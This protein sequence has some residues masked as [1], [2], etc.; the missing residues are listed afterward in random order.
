MSWTQ[1]LV[2]TSGIAAAVQFAAFFMTEQVRL[3]RIAIVANVAYI[4]Y[5]VAAQA[6]MTLLLHVTLLPLNVRRLRGLLHE[7]ALIASAVSA[8]DVS[9]AWLLQFMRREHVAGGRTL[10]HKGD[11]A[12]RM[13]FVAAGRLRIPELNMSLGPG[14]LIGEVG[15]FTVTGTRTQSV[16]TETDVE[17]MVLARDEALRL[18]QRDPAFGI[19]LTRLITRRLVDDLEHVRAAPV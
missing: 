12:D 15:I 8:D 3:R 11:A 18:Y 16:E 6:P 4:V 7:R 13:Y 14:T 17:L 9:T 5:A 10:F 1:L 19:Y 2:V